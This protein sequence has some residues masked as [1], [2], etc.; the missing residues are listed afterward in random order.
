MHDKI[1]RFFLGNGISA[2]LLHWPFSCG[3][4]L[5]TGFLRAAPLNGRDFC[6]L[7]NILVCEYRSGNPRTAL[8]RRGKSSRVPLCAVSAD[9]ESC[10]P[11]K[12]SDPSP[13][14]RGMHSGATGSVSWLHVVHTACSPENRSV[15]RPFSRY[16]LAWCSRDRPPSVAVFY[17][18]VVLGDP[19][20]AITAWSRWPL[21]SPPPPQ[22]IHARHPSKSARCN[23]VRNPCQ[24]ASSPVLADHWCSPAPR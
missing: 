16:S 10:P 4:R 1:P 8:R 5:P 6:F 20:P 21:L 23:R 18:A 15:A 3:M 9:A 19:L 2:G 11:D 7:G 13:A 14:D 17:S 24:T 12:H 22:S